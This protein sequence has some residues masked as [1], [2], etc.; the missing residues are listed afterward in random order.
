[1]AL[2]GAETGIR[3][4]LVTVSEKGSAQELPAS[5]RLWLLELGFRTFEF[6]R[7]ALHRDT[8]VALD[9]TV[10]IVLRT[11]PSVTPGLC[12]FIRSVTSAYLVLVDGSRSPEASAALR[13]NDVDHFTPELPEGNWVPRWLESLAEHR[14]FTSQRE[15]ALTR[16][17][18][19]I[20]LG[21][22]TA[23]L[24]GQP[25]SLTKIEFDLL[26]LLA[27][28]TQRVFSREEILSCIWEGSWHGEG[29]MLDVHIANLRRKLGESGREQRYIRTVR[30]VGF[31]LVPAPAE[32]RSTQVMSRVK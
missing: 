21:Q 3:P 26:A 4:T 16:G 8:L 9:P 10:V 31:Q 23:H 15:P 11:E 12:R 24:S 17:A 18:I 6:A 7:G 20:D 22:R 1:M 25:L 30:G 2:W 28:D 32:I 29:A 14:G 27:S 5:W 13:A 19:T